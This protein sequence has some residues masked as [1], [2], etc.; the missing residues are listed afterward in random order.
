MNKK[1]ISIGIII[2]LIVGGALFAVIK[3]RSSGEPP[4]SKSNEVT[5]TPTPTEKL[6]QVD[7]SVTAD[8]VVNKARTAV[9]MELVGL[10]GKYDGISYELRYASDD[11]EKGAVGGLK[12]PIPLKEGSDEFS[13]EVELGTCS[14]G[15]KC[16]YDK[17]VKNF[18]LTI[19]LHTTDGNVEI[20][21]KMFEE[22]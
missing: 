8:L 18:S 5:V 11:G 6:K 17:G 3:G 4:E 2:A 22:L 12:T 13:R 20:L 7:D 16:R 14:T 10:A 19:K 9:T 21:Q 1:T 15:G